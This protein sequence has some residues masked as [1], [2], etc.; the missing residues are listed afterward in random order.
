MF[1]KGFFILLIN[2]LI[3]QAGLCQRVITGAECTG[4]YLPLL[5]GKRVGLVIN[6]TSR[7]GDKLLADTLL[8]RGVRLVK[9]FVPEHGFRGIG[10][11][12]AHIRNSRDSATGLPLISLYGDNKKPKQA[13]LDDVDVLLYDLQDVGVRFYTYISTLQY[14]MEACAENGKHLVILDRPDPNGNYVD[15]PVLDTALQSFVG[16]QPVPIVYGLTPGEYA[17]MLI[18]ER[19][20]KNVARLRMD[21]IKCKDWDHATRYTL[22]VAPSP[23][24]RTM[25]AVYMYPSLC[26]FEGTVISVGRGTDKPFQQWGHPAL[27]VKAADSFRPASTVG[28]TKPPYEGQTCYG[29]IATPAQIAEAGNGLQIGYLIEMYDKYPDKE[30]FFNAFFE[31][32]AGTTALRQQIISGMSAADIKASWAPGLTAFKKLRKKYLLY[33]DFE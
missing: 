27:S 16:M 4:A 19:W 7:I 18:G 22:P 29:R 13:Q 25:Q 12:G 9:I 10:D 15:G 8:R 14:V 1:K 28:A 30:Q 11:A 17:R 3:V 2:V 23:N 21:V 20:I 31:K 5:T 33:R 6:Q 24:L 32:L 26:L